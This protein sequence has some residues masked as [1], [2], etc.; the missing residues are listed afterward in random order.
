M[1]APRAELF[2]G[3][4]DGETRDAAHPVA[5][6]EFPAVATASDGRCKAHRYEWRAM[7]SPPGYYYVGV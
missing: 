3:P 7:A 5:V 2:G 1:T 4:K 6:L